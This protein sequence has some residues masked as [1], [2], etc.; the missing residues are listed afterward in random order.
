MYGF[1]D[2]RFYFARHAIFPSVSRES[3]LSRLWYRGCP[4]ICSGHWGSVA[5]QV[6]VVL[7][8]GGVLKDMRHEGKNTVT[9]DN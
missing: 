4:G 1:F 2:C 8:Q 9:V 7:R 5:A 6:V 3:L